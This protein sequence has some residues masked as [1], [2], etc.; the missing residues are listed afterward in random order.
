[1]DMTKT[2]LFKYE[3]YYRYRLP[4]TILLIIAENEE[5]AIE[6]LM[7]KLNRLGEKFDKRDL[8]EEYP[9]D[10]GIITL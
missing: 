4:P 10:Y 8:T 5:K 3:I 2:K 7:P 9:D 6:K 1:M